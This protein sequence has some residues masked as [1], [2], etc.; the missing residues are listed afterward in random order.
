MSTDGY[1]EN[2]SE[3]FSLLAECVSTAWL[4]PGTGPWH[5]L[6][7]AVRSS[8]GICHFRFL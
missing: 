6:Y 5:P 3:D 1:Q 4:R 7:R 2:D 8:P